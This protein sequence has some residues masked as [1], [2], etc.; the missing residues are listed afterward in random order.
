MIRVWTDGCC[1]SEAHGGG[2]PG[3]WAF[4]GLRVGTGESI[5][6]SGGVPFADAGRMELLAVLEALRRFRGTDTVEVFTDSHYIAH[7][8]K[9]LGSW[10]H[11]G[12][13]YTHKRRRG[14]PIRDLDLWQSAW[15]L[16]RNQAVKIEQITR[17]IHAANVEAD[18]AAKVAM[19][20]EAGVR[21]PSEQRLMR[22]IDNALRSG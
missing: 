4:V 13:R 1:S 11:A 8:F 2:G 20:R 18:Q 22:A 14:L 15:S 5:R 7:G 16:Y 12:W 10:H 6:E 3:G 19:R 21:T 17:A 9:K